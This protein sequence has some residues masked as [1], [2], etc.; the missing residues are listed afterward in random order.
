[1]VVDSEEWWVDRCQDQCPD[2]SD[3]APAYPCDYFPTIC[4]TT[5][6]AGTVYNAGPYAANVPCELGERPYVAKD[7]R[8]PGGLRVHRPRRRLGEQ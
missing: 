6:G 2:P 4:D 7:A 8:P 5:I 1:M 3:D